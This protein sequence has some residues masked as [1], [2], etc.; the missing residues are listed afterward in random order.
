MSETAKEILGLDYTFKIIDD[1]IPETFIATLQRDEHEFTDIHT[2]VDKHQYTDS[3]FRTDKA[4]TITDIKMADRLLNYIKPNL[5]KLYKSYTIN[6]LLRFTKSEPGN[7]VAPHIDSTN[8][9]EG[10]LSII[11]YLSNNTDGATRFININ[12]MQKYD[13]LPKVGRVV[14][15]DHRL[16]HSGLAPSEN[17][18][19]MRT[20][21]NGSND[22][23]INDPDLVWSPFNKRY[24]RRGIMN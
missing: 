8:Q 24:M 10:Y 21:L 3:S 17:K 5:P 6:P 18:Y 11:V 12:T 7:T 13:V 23:K 14:I 20:N 4:T 19:I 1:V 22:V 16:T 2:N 15:F 9:K